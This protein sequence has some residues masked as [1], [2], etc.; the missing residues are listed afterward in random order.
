MTRDDSTG[1]WNLPGAGPEAGSGQVELWIR[2]V[3]GRDASKLHERW[4]FGVRCC[5]ERGGLM[6]ATLSHTIVFFKVV[7][8]TSIPTQIRQ[9]ILYF[10]NSKG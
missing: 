6:C 7:L 5:A 4:W 10:M 2:R 9:L 8:Q 1:L 3:L